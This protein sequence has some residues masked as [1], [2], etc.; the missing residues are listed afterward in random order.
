MRSRL[1][2]LFSSLPN[3]MPSRPKF[4]SNTG[5]YTIVAPKPNNSLELAKRSQLNFPCEIL[6]VGFARII[7]HSNGLLLIHAPFWLTVT[8]R[9]WIHVHGKQTL[10]QIETCTPV[11]NGYILAAKIAQLRRRH[12]DRMSTNIPASLI[13]SS[14]VSEIPVR[15]VDMSSSGLAVAVQSEVGTG[16]CVGVKMEGE[17]TLG[18]TRY[19]VREQDSFRVGIEK[20]I[21]LA[22]YSY[23]SA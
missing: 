16:L 10:A 1:T 15:I 9:V 3:S 12:E 8:A 18:R 14:D 22:A 13:L 5:K 2:E 19:C 4:K 6:K 20:C 7:G 11:D 23:K 17:F 21:S